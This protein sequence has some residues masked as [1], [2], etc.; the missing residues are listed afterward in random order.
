MGVMGV[1]IQ[2]ISKVLCCICNAGFLCRSSQ[3]FAKYYHR[4]TPQYYLLR[5]SSKIVNSKPWFMALFSEPSQ[6][7]LIQHIIL[8]PL[9]FHNCSCSKTSSLMEARADPKKLPDN[10]SGNSTIWL[11]EK[12]YFLAKDA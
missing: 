7:Y 12:S 10:W 3:C 5:C 9:S 2:H 8:K 1:I 4:F 6:L 11:M